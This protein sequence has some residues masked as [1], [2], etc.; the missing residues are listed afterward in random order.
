MKRNTHLRWGNAVALLLVCVT[1]MGTTSSWAQISIIGGPLEYQPFEIEVRSNDGSFCMNQHRFN[2]S[3]RFG[4]SG[5]IVDVAPTLDAPWNAD[6]LIALP[7]CTRTQSIRLQLPGLPRGRHPIEVRFGDRVFSEVSIAPLST[8]ASVESFVTAYVFNGFQ[9]NYILRVPGEGPV[10]L[11]VPLEGSS[12]GRIVEDSFKAIRFG[13]DRALPGPSLARLFV[14]TYPG[15]FRGRYVTTDPALASRLSQAWHG[16]PP[17]P[18]THVVGRA[19]NGACP[20]GMKPVYQVWHQ[21]FLSHRWTT[22]PGT[23]AT[24]VANGALAE[25]IAFCSPE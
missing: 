7:R 13:V 6:F 25:G 2:T 3:V 9:S 5:L 19:V 10:T 22:E 11:L 17:D 12:V 16:R 1:L 18:P 4:S 15:G 23:Y 8:D 21:E 24:L 14:I 20:L